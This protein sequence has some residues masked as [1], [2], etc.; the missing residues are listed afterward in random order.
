MELEFELELV[1]VDG[2]LNAGEKEERSNFGN[3]YR[4]LKWCPFLKNFEKVRRKV[5]CCETNIYNSGSW[6]GFPLCA[7]IANENAP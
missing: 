6:L 7:Y 3:L 2:E 4:N 5:S 1:E